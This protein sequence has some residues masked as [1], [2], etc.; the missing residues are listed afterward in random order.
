MK[1]NNSTPKKSLLLTALFV[2]AAI[3]ISYSVNKTF[4][5]PGDFSNAALWNG[6]TLPV[7]GDRLIIMGTCFIDAAMTELAY[8]DLQ[9]GKGL[10][11]NMAGTIF[12]PIGSTKTLNVANISAAAGPGGTVDMTN[13]GTW[14]IRGAWNNAAI[15]FIPGIGTV[16]IEVS[17]PPFNLPADVPAYN[18]LIISPGSG[19]N[20]VMGTSIT[21]KNLTINAGANFDTRDG[22]NIYNITI[23]GDWTNVGTFD[24]QTSTVIFNGSGA[25]SITN[26]AGE[27]FY[28][29]T[30]NKP[31]GDVT[32]NDDITVNNLLA[33]T[34]GYLVL[35]SND[36]TIGNTGT[37]SGASISSYVQ[38][39]GSGVMKKN[40]TATGSFAFPVGDADD[41]S[42]MSIDLNSATFGGSDFLSVKITDAAHPNFFPGD[43]Y[44]TRYWTVNAGGFTAINYDVD[45]TYVDADAVGTE[46]NLLAA[47]WD[48]TAWTAYDA[49]NAPANGLTSS[50]GITVIPSNHDFSAGNN[51]VL[52]IELL[53]FKVQLKNKVTE[54]VWT[55][56]TENN[57][58]YFTIERSADGKNWTAIGQID[59]AGNSSTMLN[60]SATDNKPLYGISYYRL[61]QT[62]FDGRTDFS[63]IVS[64]NNLAS[65]AALNVYPNPAVNG[66]TVTVNYSNPSGDG[67]EVLITVFDF[68]GRTLYSKVLLQEKEGVLTAIDPNDKLAP[69]VYFVTGSSNNEIFQKRLV[70]ID[71]NPAPSFAKQ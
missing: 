57:N 67:Q 49:V 59:G 3:G 63:K 20:A 7:A 39:D 52:P 25:Q 21:V 14:K 31:S 16:D 1:T 38:A 56:A 34:N 8:S 62:G 28:S 48:G 13:G 47:R 29:L 65:N 58:D 66:Q 22:A 17:P 10:P 6:G 26:A 44:L 2:F 18:N 60:Y 12:W 35:G 9:V 71:N 24:E 30:M 5:G 50:T 15:S 53:N 70:V 54:V 37:T 36:L 33:L 51:F 23:S 68:I 11:D 69:G 42:P 45:Y 4:T 41:Y 46:A 27:T 61:K 55:T 43:D 40:Y 32:L 19:M 64:L